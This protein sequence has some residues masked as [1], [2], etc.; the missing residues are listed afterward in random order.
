MCSSLEPQNRCRSS[1]SRWLPEHGG[2]VMK[3]LDV[4]WS[5]LKTA[6]LLLVLVAVLPP[7]SAR[8]VG[9]PAEEPTRAGFGK[10]PQTG[11]GGGDNGGSPDKAAPQVPEKLA[12]APDL[13]KDPM[14]PPVIPPQNLATP[15][16]KA[17]NPQ[18]TENEDKGF[19]F[20][21]VLAVLLTLALLS[22]AVILL[23]RHNKREQP[24][25]VKIEG[26]SVYNPSKEKNYP[27]S[28]YVANGVGVAK[29]IDHGG[30]ESNW[31][32]NG[33]GSQPAAASAPRP[34]GNA[35]AALGPQGGE[36]RTGTPDRRVDQAVSDVAGLRH[37][38]QNLANS[39]ITAQRDLQDRFTQLSQAVTN[40]I[41]ANEAQVIQA[42]RD[43]AEQNL[44]S[45]QAQYEQLWDE[46]LRGTDKG[47]PVVFTLV[48]DLS[49]TGILDADGFSHWMQLLLGD[50]ARVLSTQSKPT[51]PRL[52]M[53]AN[54]L[55]EAI[56]TLV[57]AI[58]WSGELNAKIDSKIRA[59]ESP[60]H[61]DEK[62]VLDFIDF[63]IPRL[64]PSGRKSLDD[65]QQDLWKR[66]QRFGESQGIELIYP[67]PGTPFSG[68]DCNLVEVDEE[69]RFPKDSIV[70]VRL[71]GIR[72]PG[73]NRK[74]EVA[75]RG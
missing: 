48:R 42:L 45:V 4:C 24:H 12:S 37:D 5:G 19:P 7:A 67:E 29:T 52:N 43:R 44:R 55:G 54:S 40:T 64:D 63:V 9:D 18:A 41:R 57:Q 61:P 3:S 70:R 35:P 15:H 22:V 50:A 38:L 53:Q 75:V 10:D 30:H 34:E 51:P 59:L 62:D 72:R 58:G 16:A 71:V 20:E 65:A 32:T 49:T 46:A 47:A 36:G 39:L 25:K 11:D 74:A 33:S 26:R 60:I 21:V 56:E 31:M 17:Q 8:G 73:Q 1:G 13:K 27:H 69:S 28:D 6:C 66:V 14:L 68:T 2:V 23:R